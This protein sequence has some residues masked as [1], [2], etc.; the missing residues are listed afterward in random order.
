[1]TTVQERFIRMKIKWTAKGIIPQGNVVVLEVAVALL[2][3]QSLFLLNIYLFI[4]MSVQYTRS[5]RPRWMGWGQLSRSKTSSITVK[6]TVS[7]VTL[8][9]WGVQ[10]CTIK[11]MQI[12][13]V[14][15]G[16][17]YLVL[18]LLMGNRGEQN[19]KK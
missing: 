13:K 14:K 6:S 15:M 4:K 1:M 2:S 16:A 19:V 10:T 18:E 17:T 11:E 12:N 5:Q 7:Y 3:R 8:I 9:A